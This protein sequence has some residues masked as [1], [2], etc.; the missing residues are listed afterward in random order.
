MSLKFY[1]RIRKINRVIRFEIGWPAVLEMDLQNFQCVLL[2]TLFKVGV[3]NIL[4]T[5]GGNNFN[6]FLMKENTFLVSEF[7]KLVINIFF[8][9][10]K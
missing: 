2:K 8:K 4:K 10:C 7:K 9:K 5:N 6:F 1:W 3:T